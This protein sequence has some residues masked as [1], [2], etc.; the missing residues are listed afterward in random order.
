MPLTKQQLAELEHILQARKES[1]LAEMQGEVGRARD[2]T[3]GALAGPVTDTGDAA[4]ADLLSDL[5]MAE[6]TRDLGEFRGIEAA[7]GRLAAGT[8]G[9]CVDCGRDI[10]IE[11]LRVQPTALRCID[12]QAVHEKTYSHPAEPTL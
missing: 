11:R 6:V 2:E 3:F 9:A 8:Y 5:D 4:S 12:C 1:L 10:D 7:L